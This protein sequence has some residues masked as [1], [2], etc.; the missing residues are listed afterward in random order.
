MTILIFFPN[1][2][3]NVSFQNHANRLKTRKGNNSNQRKIKSSL[4][5]YIFFSVEGLH[6]S[7]NPGNCDKF[8]DQ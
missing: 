7:T 8:T 5:Q 4:L 2:L 1:L 3:L 6:F